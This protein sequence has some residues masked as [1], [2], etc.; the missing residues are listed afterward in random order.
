MNLVGDPAG[1]E[2][3][4]KIKEERKEFLKFLLA[5]VKTSLNCTATFKGTDGRQW[6]LTF[7]GRRDE[8]KVDPAP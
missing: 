8:L 2:E 3:L 7:D 5:E 6:K 1:L 4:K